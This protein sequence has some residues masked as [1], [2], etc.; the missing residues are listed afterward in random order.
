M[1]IYLGKL[2]FREGAICETSRRDT[3]DWRGFF[4]CYYFCWGGR[5]GRGPIIQPL[6]SFLSV[7]TLVIMTMT[8]IFD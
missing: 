1:D 2:G 5:D 4:F 6:G 7:S 8:R 3:A